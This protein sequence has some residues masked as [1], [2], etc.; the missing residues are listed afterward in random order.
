MFVYGSAACH[1][2]IV[3]ILDM[4]VL[5]PLSVYYPD[6][7]KMHSDAGGIHHISGGDPRYVADLNRSLGMQKRQVGDIIRTPATPCKLQCFE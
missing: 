7:H 1:V 4:C 5:C 3:T 6:G 2:C